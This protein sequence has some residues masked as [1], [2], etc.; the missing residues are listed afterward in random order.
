MIHVLTRW[1]FGYLQKAKPKHTAARHE[2]IYGTV[3][4]HTRS[5]NRPSPLFADAKIV[6]NGCSRIARG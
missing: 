4:I 1:S 2:V 6:A 3:V 5:S